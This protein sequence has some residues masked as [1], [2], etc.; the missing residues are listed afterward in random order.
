M[1]TFLLT[2]LACSISQILTWLFV[3]GFTQSYWGKNTVQEITR[4]INSFCKHYQKMKRN[5]DANKDL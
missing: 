3:Q 4:F 5:N 1:K 2:I